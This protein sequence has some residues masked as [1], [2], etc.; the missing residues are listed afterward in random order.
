M[1]SK[2]DE[3]TRF[4]RK[5]WDILL[6]KVVP[7]G[8]NVLGI[9]SS[10]AHSVSAAYTGYTMMCLESLTVANLRKCMEEGAFFAASKNL[11]NYDEIKE[12]ADLLSS[13]TDSQKKAM[14]TELTTLY[15]QIETELEKGD[16]GSKYQAPFDVDAPEVT[17]VTVNDTE[18]TIAL[19]T[20]SDALLVRWIA[21]GKL[22]ATGNSIDLDDYSDEIGSYVR[23]EIF[24]KG[25]IVYTQAFT[26]D[27]DGA[28]TAEKNFFVDL[29][30]L[31]SFVPDTI[32]KALAKSPVFV[33]IWDITNK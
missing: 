23:A 3:R 15:K 8:R 5:L 7:T 13:S 20:T 12:I 9:A 30:K 6:E 16:Q 31:A 33:W 18:D 22:I 10:D 19:Q 14:G 1:N 25:G 17:K 29:W 11:G 21:N 28:P 32:V 4:D 26:L 24:G 2:G 27:Y